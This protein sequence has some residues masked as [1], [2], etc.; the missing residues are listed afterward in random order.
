MSLFKVNN[1]TKRYTTDNIPFE[2]LRDVSVTL[3][4]E[5]TY[6]I[7]GPSGAGKSTLLHILGTLDTPTSGEVYFENMQLSALSE[8]E[9][10]VFR[11]KTIGFVFQ[12]HHLLPDFSV[13]ENV[14]LPL[15]IGGVKKTQAQ[16]RAKNFLEKVGLSGKYARRPSEL[17]GGEKQRVAI[18]RALVNSPRV[19]LADEPTG[20]LDS[21]MG[22]KVFDLLLGLNE[23]LKT[24]L[25]VVTHNEELALRLD[26]KIRIVDGKIAQI[27][28]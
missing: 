6:A 7:L 25:V 18:A 22:Q 19:V 4:A 8:E 12:F 11:N 2:A 28:Q 1:L 20:N 24:T 9:L 27:Y 10:S 21:D 26:T 5:K 3:E 23:E 15:L 14:A 17:S 16:D 13:L